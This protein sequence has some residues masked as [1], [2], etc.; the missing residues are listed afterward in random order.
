MD[1]GNIIT[2]LKALG[3]KENKVVVYIGL[4]SV[5]KSSTNKLFDNE[6]DTRDR[7]NKIKEKYHVLVKEPKVKVLL[8]NK[9]LLELEDNSVNL[10]IEDEE[11]GLLSLYHDMIHLHDERIVYSTSDEY[12]ITYGYGHVFY[13]E[14]FM[15]DG[16]CL[17]GRLGPI[18]DSHMYVHNRNKFY[19]VYRI[20]D[21]YDEEYEHPITPVSFSWAGTDR[22]KVHTI[23]GHYV[24]CALVEM[25]EDDAKDFCVHKLER[26]VE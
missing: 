3:Y 11:F 8:E 23:D 1:V 24:L 4:G 17:M 18:T 5:I 12:A 13:H 25:R 2:K 7:D 20:D 6:E 21:D 10:M 19:N 16:I 9:Y 14:V 15:K 26:L 22:V